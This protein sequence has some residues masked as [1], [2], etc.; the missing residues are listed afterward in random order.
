M[1]FQPIIDS[2]T[3]ELVSA[4]GLARWTHPTHGPIGPDTFVPLAEEAG[5]MPAL[6]AWALDTALGACARWQRDKPGVSVSVNLS[7]SDLQNPPT[8]ALIA[9]ALTQH[10]L[11]S[12]LLEVELTETT[13]MT[14]LATAQGMLNDLADLGI[15]LGIDDFGTGYSSL[16][17]LQRL[18]MMTLKIDRSFVIGM[19]ENEGNAAIV[20]MIIR[21]AHALGM[22]TIA[23]G[24]ED[25]ATWDR[26]AV[27][28]CDRMQGFGIA[29][30]MPEADLLTW[31]APVRL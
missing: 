6:T 31:R 12:S 19:L 25:Q 21:L 23:E 10:H 16:A 20:T 9:A 30:P 7:A 5:I 2:T 13:I 15:G 28:G 14:D 22:S 24:V 11:P 18:P 17:Y 29:R 8:A 3:G 4:E 1:V 26:L 27:L